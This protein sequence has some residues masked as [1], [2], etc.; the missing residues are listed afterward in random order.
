MLQDSDSLIIAGS[1]NV[2]LNIYRIAS[3]VGYDIT[4]IDNRVETLTWERFPEASELLLGDIVE[5]LKSIDINDSTSIVLVTYQHAFDEAALQAVVESPA[6]YIGIMG[7]KHKVTAYFSKLNSLGISE[8]L[9]GKVHVPIGLDL[10]GQR[11]AEIALSVVAE[12]QAVKYER[13]G[14][15][16]TIKRAVSRPEIRE[17]LF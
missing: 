14:G 6:R 11:A 5:T 1:G 4:V 17:E 12:L 10:G 2:A 7:N 9:I 3:I 15:Y 8:E 13:A 16:L